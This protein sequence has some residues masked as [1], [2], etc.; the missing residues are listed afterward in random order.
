METKTKIRI[1]LE[2]LE[3]DIHKSWLK[4]LDKVNEMKELIR[5]LNK[6]EESESI[7]AFFKKEEGTQSDFEYFMKNFSRETINN[8][9]KQ[10]FVYGENGDDVALEVLMCYLRIL[11]KFLN[12]TKPIYIFL[13][14][15]IKEIFDSTKYFYKPTIF[16]N[17]RIDADRRT[18]KQMTSEFFNVRVYF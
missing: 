4:D 15:S 8:I 12:Q 18:K 10:H 6:I 9:L 3:D 7:E 17:M 1:I 11:V 13:F 2:Q 14:E 16:G 5:L